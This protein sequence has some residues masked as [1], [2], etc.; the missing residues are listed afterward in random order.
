MEGRCAAFSCTGAY[1]STDFFFF[2]SNFLSFKG[3]MA[4]LAALVNFMM[5]EGGQDQPENAVM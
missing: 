2:T 3:F 1:G 4:S 5:R